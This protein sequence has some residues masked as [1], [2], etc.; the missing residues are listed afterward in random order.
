MEKPD[1][2]WAS[3]AVAE[4]TRDGSYIVKRLG[5]NEVGG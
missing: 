5:G 3:N 4:R 2:A 1:A